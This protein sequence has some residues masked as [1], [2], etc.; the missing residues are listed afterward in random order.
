MMSHSGWNL[1]GSMPPKQRSSGSYRR[2]DN[3]KSP[4]LHS[5]S[6]QMQCIPC[7]L[8]EIWVFTWTR[9]SR[10]AHRYPRPNQAASP[11][12]DKYE[13]YA[14]GLPRHNWTDCSPCSML[15]H[16]W[17]T[18]RGNVILS[19]P[20]LASYIGYE[21]RKH[22]LLTG[23]SGLLLFTWSGSLVLDGWASPC[24]GPGHWTSHTF[25]V[26]GIIDSSTN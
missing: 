9:T 7:S 20:Y 6:N 26:D 15:R 14:A 25:I 5:L 12:C 8:S 13:A 22:W 10:C 16:V 18:R 4:L 17:C 23:S 2:V 3:I 1:T 24:F 11:W 19:H 21:C